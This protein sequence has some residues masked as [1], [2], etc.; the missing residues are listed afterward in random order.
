VWLDRQPIYEG[1]EGTNSASVHDDG[2][3]ATAMP[4]TEA[5]TMTEVEERI[6]AGGIYLLAGIRLIGRNEGIKMQKREY[7]IEKR[8]EGEKEMMDLYKLLPSSGFPTGTRR[9]IGG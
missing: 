5:R 4:M 2:D 9:D 1:G 3:C 8:E 6:M 7:G